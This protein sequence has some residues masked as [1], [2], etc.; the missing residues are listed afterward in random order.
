[1]RQSR[2]QELKTNELSIYL[3]QAYDF[4]S[5]HL[6][7]VVGAVVVVVLIIIVGTLNVRSQHQARVNA[8]ERINDIKAGRIARDA[9]LLDEVK[10]LAN[11]YG[12]DAGLGPDILDLQASLAH[13]LALNLTTGPDKA[14]RAELLKEA[15]EACERAIRQFKDRSE[16]V[17]RA[18]F[19][20]AGVAETVLLDGQVEPDKQKQEIRDLYQQVIDG[21][22]NP[23]KELAKAQLESLDQ[24][25]AKLE[26]VAAR[27]PAPSPTATQA[28]ATRPAVQPTAVTLTPPTRP[29]A[30]TGAAAQTPPASTRPAVPAGT[31]GAPPPS[32]NTATKPAR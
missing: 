5:R 14:R 12:G 8:M 11:S 32:G 1:M 27:P 6:T 24:R 26:I 9:R 10:D 2:R 4:V 19:T 21:P 20:L 28:A 29:A 17:A 18:R 30:A 31:T 3:Q 23:Y 13:E 16:I 7:Y 25:T 22:A 15:R